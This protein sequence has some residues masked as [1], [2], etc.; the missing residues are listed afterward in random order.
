MTESNGELRVNLDG[1]YGNQLFMYFN[2]RIF[3]E[4]NRLNLITN[5]PD[6]VL[7]IIDNKYFGVPP[8]NMNKIIIKDNSYN[9]NQ[10]CY[11]YE[12]L[13]NYIFDGYFQIE[14]IIYENLDLIKSWI[15]YDINK[16]DIVTLH[17]RLGDFY[18]A[19]SRHLIVSQDY[20][21]DCIKK[22]CYNYN[23][24]YI[25]C[26]SIKESWENLYMETL[27][28]KIKDIGKNPIYKLQSIKDDYQNII[29]STVIITSNS[30]FCFWPMVLSNVD[31]IISYPYFA[32][33]VNI[34]NSLGYWNG[35]HKVFKYNKNNKYIFNNEYNKDI[36]NY[37]ENMSKYK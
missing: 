23:D 6:G 36:I 32:I 9:S 24:I 11:N 20:Y 28:Q 37:F 16:K 10:N 30:T 34:D 18:F 1:K 25:I 29:D 3:A 7:N 19:D 22:Y 14:D 31:K 17:I 13:G 21:I 15:K 5:K 35:I 4:K 2:A 26:D 33:D 8:S 12:G 27:K